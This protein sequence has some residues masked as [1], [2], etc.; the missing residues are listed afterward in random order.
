MI[1]QKHMFVVEHMDPE[2][3][4][5]QAIEYKCI[6]KECLEAGAQFLLTSISPNL[7]LPAHFEE[8]AGL[9]MEQRTAEAVFANRKDRVCLLDPAASKELSHMDGDKFEIFLFGG[10]LGTSSACNGGGLCSCGG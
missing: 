10:I 2:L 1:A 4:D 7:N 6:A 5:W 8:A 3:D 9:R